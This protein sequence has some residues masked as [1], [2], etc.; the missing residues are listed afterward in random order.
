MTSKLDSVTRNIHSAAANAG[1][2]ATDITL[3]AVSKTKSSN[4]ITPILDQGHRVFG[5]NRIQ[6]AAGKW[7]ELR[8]LYSQVELHLIGPLQSNKVRQALRLFDV[9]ET[10]D[11]PKLAR[12]I[13]RISQEENIS[14]Q[15]YI[16]INVGREA[17]K[18]GIDPE[19]ADSFITLCRDELKLPVIG[20][21]CIP[22]ADQ[23]PAP[24]FLQLKEI[25]KRNGLKKLSMGMS[26]DYQ[27]A[28]RCGAT[29][30][31]VGTAIFG[32]RS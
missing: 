12:A 23:D 4:A 27:V 11:R 9:I 14:C 3:V 5:E 20:L 31:R 32:A 17:Q 21:M 16:Q 6:E 13:A 10:I 29:S 28:I 2:K 18:A 25:A 15:Y 1:R 26:G 19:E 7:P 8:A 22:P 24:Y 30:V